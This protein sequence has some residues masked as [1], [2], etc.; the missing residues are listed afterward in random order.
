MSNVT[1]LPQING[2]VDS[3]TGVGTTLAGAAALTGAVN[4]VT[5]AVGQTAVI[6]P[7]KGDYPS[8]P[9]V[10]HVPTATA[11][12]VFPPSASISINQVAAGG[13]FSVAQGKTATF[14]Q[15]SATQIISTLSA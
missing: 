14:V 7:L 12:L 9:V 10:V 2:G 3:V 15:V 5:T 1:Q 8:Q 13:S 6:L 11:A 4:M